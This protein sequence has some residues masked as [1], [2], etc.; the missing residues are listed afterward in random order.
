MVNR[1]YDTMEIIAARTRELGS[2]L[3]TLA[4]VASSSGEKDALV[5][6]IGIVESILE[7]IEY[8][9]T[10]RVQVIPHLPEAESR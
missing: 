5:R 10:K 7:E 6:C 4:E 2:A 9:E 8:A 3:V 1:L